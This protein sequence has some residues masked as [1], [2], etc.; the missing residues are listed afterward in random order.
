MSKR[1]PDSSSIQLELPFEEWRD[2]PAWED[3]YQISNLGRVRR[4][5]ARGYHNK[6]K[7]GGL[8]KPRPHRQGYVETKLSRNSQNK[9]VM[10][11]RLVMLAFVGEP[12]KGMEV[13]HKNGIKNDNRLENLEY[14]TRSENMIHR[15]DVLGKGNEGENS[16]NAKLKDSD[17]PQ[18]RL[19]S[20]AGFTYTEIAL[21]Y[22]V[23]A[24][25]ISCVVRGKAWTHV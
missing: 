3:L 4:K 1:T 7:A 23:H 20:K 13:N 8:L 14:V 16:P 2:I 18:I 15:R 25:T 21:R 10:T 11:H 5:V 19:L 12:P 9:V 6:Y 17:I 22:G 24:V